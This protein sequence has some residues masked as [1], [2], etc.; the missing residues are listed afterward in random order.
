MPVAAV[1]ALA[2][3]S[4]SLAHGNHHHRAVK[5]A[6]PQTLNLNAYESRTVATWQ[7][8]TWQ[9]S[10]DYCMKKVNGY[11]YWRSIIKGG[12]CGTVVKSQPLVRGRH[13]TATVSGLIS[14]WSGAWKNTCG[15]PIVAQDAGTTNNFNASADAQWTFA[16]KK[17][18]FRC[19][20]LAPH[21]PLVGAGFRVNTTGNAAPQG[22]RYPWMHMPKEYV[23]SDHTYSFN[24]TGTG[25]SVWFS[26]YDHYVTDNR[27]SL[28]IKLTPAG[29]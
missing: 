26:I 5:A 3:P 2:V 23:K 10:R 9:K 28:T 17:S 22:W 8:R 25:K 1:A 24:V 21:L 16:T 6:T 19:S 11:P 29:S 12:R 13:Y 4:L 14:H 20:I 15:S 7:K 27:G 18:R